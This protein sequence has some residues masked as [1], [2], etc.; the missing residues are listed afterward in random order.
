MLL[1]NEVEVGIVKYL[2]LEGAHDRAYLRQALAIN[3][4]KFRESSDL[5]HVPF[6]KIFLGSCPDCPWEHFCQLSSP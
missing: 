2:K 6:W 4:E 1:Y 3:V 5:G